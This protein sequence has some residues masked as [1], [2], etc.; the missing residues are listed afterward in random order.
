MAGSMCP[1]NQRI[2]DKIVIITGGT[3]GIGKETAIELAKRGGHIILAVRNK[4][5][6]IKIANELGN[7]SNAKISINLIDLS[8]LKS[9]RN[10]VNNLGKVIF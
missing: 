3:S 8:S 10:F 2:D 7:I 4:D 1:S 6:G 5:Y 9:V